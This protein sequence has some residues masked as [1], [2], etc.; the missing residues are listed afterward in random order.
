VTA[1]D[2]ERV[3]AHARALIE[4]HE[5]RY[6]GSRDATESERIAVLALSFTVDDVL[7]AH[8]REE[9]AA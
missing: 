7:D 4:A 5:R 3:V 6:P 9:Q 1:A 2:V 8:R